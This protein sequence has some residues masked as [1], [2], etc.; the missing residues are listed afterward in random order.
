M[1][2]GCGDSI[3]TSFTM[4]ILNSVGPE[5]EWHGFGVES[6]WKVM[7]LR[8]GF[9]RQRKKNSNNPAVNGYLF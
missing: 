4:L 1:L 6:C 7:S 9:A 2:Y 5:V 3:I 8:L